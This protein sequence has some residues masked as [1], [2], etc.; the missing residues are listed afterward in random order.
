[1]TLSSINQEHWLWWRG[2]WWG[3]MLSRLFLHTVPLSACCSHTLFQRFCLFCAFAVTL[4]VPGWSSSLFAAQIRRPHFHE[5]L[6]ATF[7]LTGLEH[8]WARFV[9]FSWSRGRLNLSFLRYSKWE[10]ICCSI[11]EFGIIQ[12]IRVDLQQ[13]QDDTEFL[14]LSLNKWLETAAANTFTNLEKLCFKFCSDISSCFQ[15]LLAPGC[16]WTK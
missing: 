10:I 13:N 15:K 7:A 8:I 9:S 2:Y 3:H 14:V 12:G 16:L 6:T 11:T 5:F 1:M 4:Y